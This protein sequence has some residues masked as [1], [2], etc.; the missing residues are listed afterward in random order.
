[1]NWSEWDGTQ[2]VP[3]TLDGEWDGTTIV[4]LTASEI[5]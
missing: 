5:T 4:P 1:M 3:L 2:E